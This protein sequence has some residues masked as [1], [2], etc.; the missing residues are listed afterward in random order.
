MAEDFNEFLQSHPEYAVSTTVK[1]AANLAYFRPVEGAV[2]PY[3]VRE[4]SEGG[5]TYKI[6]Y[7]KDGRLRLVYFDDETEDGEW[8]LSMR[9]SY[10]DNLAKFM[11][12]PLTIPVKEKT[13]ATIGELK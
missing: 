8:E 11:N 9:G 7:G 4:W 2:L 12:L 3:L 13:F 6:E 1:Y 5:M 10:L